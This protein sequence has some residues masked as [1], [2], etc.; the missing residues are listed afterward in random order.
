MKLY[1]VRRGQFV[2][3][4]N[5]LHKV[6]AIKPI[7]KNPVYLYRLKDMQKLEVKASEITFIEPQ[8]QDSFI[9]YGKR[10]TINQNGFPNVG[11]YILIIKPKPDE[12]DNYF[13]NEIEKVQSIENDNVITTR[14]NGVKAKEYVLMSLGKDG[15]AHD[16]SYENPD[17]VSQTQKEEDESVTAIEVHDESLNPMIGDIYLDVH[18]HT[19]AMVIARTADEVIFGHGVHVHIAELLDEN[20]FERIY[21]ME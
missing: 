13:L 5:E 12:L 21:R 8:H 11:D 2:Y 17:L 16:I 7:Y 4:N 6:Y 19:K 9:F 3:F 15:T 20:N 10:Y 1:Q 14:D 18:Q